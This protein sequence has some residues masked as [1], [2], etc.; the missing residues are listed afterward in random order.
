M[1]LK[2]TFLVFAGSGLIF[3]FQLLCC[4]GTEGKRAEAFVHEDDSIGLGNPFSYSSSGAGDYRSLSKE[5][6]IGQ[7]SV[8]GIIRMSGDEPIAILYSQESN[9]SYYIKKSDVI[10]VSSKASSG[11]LC[12]EVYLVVK[13]VRDNE[14]ELIQQERPDKVIIIR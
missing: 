8:K 1:N 10:R 9:R 14:V 6:P 13:D 11:S 7:I 5:R 3:S 12:T 4:A 2:K